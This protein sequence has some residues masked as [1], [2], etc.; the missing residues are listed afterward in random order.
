MGLLGMTVD[1]PNVA[2]MYNYFLGGDIHTEAD[3]RAAA[4]AIAAVPETIAILRQNRAFLGR[5]VRFLTA[6]AGIDQFIDIGSGLPTEDNVHEVAQRANP[7]ARVVYVDRDPFV[8]EQSEKLLRSNPNTAFVNRDIRDTAGILESAAVHDLIDLSR[9]VAILCVAVLQFVPGE[10]EPGAILRSFRDAVAPGSHLALSHPV[11]RSSEAAQISQTYT[12][13]RSQLT[14]RTPEQVRQ[15]LA[16]WEIL[17]PGVVSLHEWRPSDSERDP[18]GD[19]F[20]CAI[21]RKP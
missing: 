20:C 15:L 2:R 19:W 5:A 16:G 18:A 8:V 6:E 11:P 21:G 4:E 13:T 9:P 17:E 7:N 1:A 14:F 12:Q 3:R 10:G